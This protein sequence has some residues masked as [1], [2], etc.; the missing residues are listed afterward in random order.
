MGRIPHFPW[1]NSQMN[2]TSGQ[3]HIKLTH[4]NC[5]TFKYCS[6]Q[7]NSASALQHS[8]TCS[9][10]MAFFGVCRLN[11]TVD[12]CVLF[13][14]CAILPYFIMLSDLQLQIQ[15]IASRALESRS[16]IIFLSCFESNLQHTAVL[17]LE[18]RAGSH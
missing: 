11:V 6:F 9:T 10:E 17:W 8:H 5:S 7:T 1:E 4:Q 3:I 13:Q 16:M 2:V 12:F 18:S 14:I 15:E